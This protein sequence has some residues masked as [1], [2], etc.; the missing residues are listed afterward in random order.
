MQDLGSLYKRHGIT[1]QYDVHQKPHGSTLHLFDVTPLDRGLYR[2][3]T[4]AMDPITG[5]VATLFQ[6]TEFFPDY[7]SL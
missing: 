3:I 5:Q 7:N 4:T 2:C 6:D 1:H